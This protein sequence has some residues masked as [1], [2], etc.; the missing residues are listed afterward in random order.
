[1]TRANQ[2]AASLVQ[3]H[4]AKQAGPAA[5]NRDKQQSSDRQ[6]GRA[7]SRPAPPSPDQPES[8]VIVDGSNVAHSTEGEN[9]ASPTSSLCATS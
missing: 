9:R 6:A 5:R 2:L 8:V 4:S 1:M 3:A 7:S